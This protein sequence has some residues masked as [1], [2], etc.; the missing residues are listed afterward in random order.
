MALDLV[1]GSCMEHTDVLGV[2]STFYTF[3][4]TLADNEIKENDSVVIAEMIGEEEFSSS[5]G[6]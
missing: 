3:E 2:V 1:V 6:K 4:F 5:H